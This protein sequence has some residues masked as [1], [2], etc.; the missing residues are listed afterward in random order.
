M[1]SYRKCTK[2]FITGF[3]CII[4]LVLWRKNV[5]KSF[6]VFFDHFPWTYE[7]KKFWM[8]K[9]C[10]QVNNG[11]HANKH[12][13][14][15]NCDLLVNFWEFLLTSLCFMMKKDHFKQKLLL[16]P[17]VPFKRNWKSF[18]YCIVYQLEW[19]IKCVKSIIVLK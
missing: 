4:L 6:M 7:V 15:A 17:Q 2:Y 8:V 11:I 18:P 9:L 3:H 1:T 5:L 14:Y 16:L 10:L 19:K 13:K 12:M